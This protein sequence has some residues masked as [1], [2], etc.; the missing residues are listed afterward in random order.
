MTVCQKNFYHG[1]KLQKQ[2]HNKGT[3]SKSY[4]FGD[5]I[6]LNSEYLKI[7]QN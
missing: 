4:V 7:K 6:W 3:E 1:K 2:S 5:K